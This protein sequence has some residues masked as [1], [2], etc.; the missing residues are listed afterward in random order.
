MLT[1]AEIVQLITEYLEGRLAPAER[2][3]FEGHIAICPPC[4][5][6]LEQ[7]RTT[8]ELVRDLREEDVPPEMEEHLLAAFRDWR[9][10][11]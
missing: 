2:R 7:M 11:E 10:D 6:F 4:R 8:V 5:A 3:R 9:C 1:C